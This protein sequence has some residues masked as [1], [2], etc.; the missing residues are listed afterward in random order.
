MAYNINE[1]DGDIIYQ[2][3]GEQ[4]VLK[5]KP[6]VIPAGG[7]AITNI[8][9]DTDETAATD[10]NVFSSLRTI[11]E[12][13]KLINGSTPDVSNLYLKK[14]FAETATQPFPFPKGINIGSAILTWDSV[15]GALKISESIYSEKELSAYGAGSTGG[16][17]GSSG[18]LGGLTNVGLWANEI[19]TVDR[20]M[21][22]LAG[23][24]HWSSKLISEIAGLDTVALGSYLTTNLYATQSFVATKVA[25]LIGS[26]PET[27]NTL[28]E[29][30]TALGNDPNFATSITT[31][32]GTKWT[33]DNT[34]IANWNSAFSAL[35]SHANKSIIDSL[36]QANLDVLAKLSVVD[37]NLK[38]DTNLWSTGE[39]SAYGT[40]AGSGGGTGLI[41]SVLESGGLG[42]S[43]LNSD[44]TNTFNAY[45]INLI[46]GNLT[47]ALGRIGALETNTP[48][49]TWGT[50]VA[51][52][53]PLSVNSVVKNISLDGHTHSY[54]PLSGGAMS[55]TNVVTNF[56]SDLL[57]GKHDTYFLY[58]DQ[59]FLANDID[60]NSV[61]YKQGYGITIQPIHRPNFS[62]QTNLPF[63]EYGQM[64]NFDG[65]TLFPFRLAHNRNTQDIWVQD[66][67]YQTTDYNYSG[68]TGWKK[69]A[70]TTDNIASATKLQNT[71][72]IWGQNFDGTGNVAGTLN[73]ASSDID[74]FAGNISF[75]GNFHI[76]S[77]NT[78]DLYLNYFNGTKTIINGGSVKGNVGIGTTNP[79]SQLS[80]GQSSFNKK[81]ALYEGEG[82]GSYFY[83]IGTYVNGSGI[84]GLG[85]W[86]GTESSLP[87]I[88][89][90]LFISRN[91]N[92]G[93]VGI[94]TDNPSALL[95][96]YGQVNAT[97]ATSGTIQS[98]AR[99]RLG[100]RDGAV[101]DFGS[102]GS[103]GLWLQATNGTDLSLKY[104]ILM[105]PNGGNILIGTTT[106]GN[107]K[108]DVN[109]NAHFSSGS[110]FKNICIEV[111]ANGNTTGRDSE[112]NCYNSSLA[113]Q[114]N[115]A[116]HL[117]LCQGGGNVLVG[118]T[119]NNGYRVD[120]NGSGHYAG[121][122]YLD[123][124]LRINNAAG[125]GVGISLF[126]ESGSN[127]NYGLMFARTT[128]KGTH[129]AVNG[130]WATY[131]TMSPDA[132]RGWIFTN[133][134]SGI[135]GNVLSISSSGNLTA[136]GEIT[137]FSASDSRLKMDIVP[138]SDSLQIIERMN[139]VS[140]KWNSIAKELN[141]LKDNNKD[142]GLI[143]QELELIMPEL[144]HSI[145][146]GQ[147]K[148]IDYVKIIPHLICAIKQL[149]N[150]IEALKNNNIIHI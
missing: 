44:L 14:D 103:S 52:Y 35:H 106:N 138:L 54:L 5:I 139:P 114:Y 94:G 123:Y 144:V 26:A 78:Q 16:G 148:S 87:T 21:V 72:S 74:G 126:A 92:G 130:D 31:L 68:G 2:V 125:S 61:V 93:Y 124:G 65:G 39:L 70:F 17:S 107:Y 19:P 82:D 140:Y 134:A 28:N 33:Q 69:L 84:A 147:Y 23:S 56:N 98:G 145:Y 75:A 105:N 110:K 133:N 86:G 7:G 119:I 150:E 90:N 47:S 66:A 118:T 50:P 34:K 32:I 120:V 18:S 76:D 25:E 80:F 9:K 8:I 43:Y 97:P 11:R 129:G 99:L 58:R 45:T 27:L 40:G 37:G 143:A 136:S 48:N 3:V 62:G 77:K 71:R 141:P 6:E 127:P 36:T 96:I 102:V 131:F 111:D 15:A 79:H 53:V 64:I 38:V 117:N 128:Y 121:E 112:I 132:G 101:L 67:G 122:L 89:P 104:P 115:T 20:V 116:N 59:S 135:G 63:V 13:K 146:G 108:L 149:K 109:G 73:M 42:G 81:F 91:L 29:L 4:V 113:L 55:N 100:R 30:A 60:Y 142:Y 51:N 24:T 88:T 22:Q 85:L 10:A 1:A 137:A 95:D 46:N 12:I 49:V 57:D 83:G 41:T